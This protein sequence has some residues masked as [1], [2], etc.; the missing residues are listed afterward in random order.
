MLV[1]ELKN[2]IIETPELINDEPDYRMYSYKYTEKIVRVEN[3]LIYNDGRSLEFTLYSPTF[4]EANNLKFNI[5]V[6]NPNFN[7]WIQLDGTESVIIKSIV[8]SYRGQVIEEIQ[9]YDIINSFID[10]IDGKNKKKL[11]KDLEVGTHND[12]IPAATAVSH[13]LFNPTQLSTDLLE[14]YSTVYKGCLSLIKN[15][16]KRYSILIRSFVFNTDDKYL[17]LFLFSQGLKIKIELN[18]NAF[19]VPVFNGSLQDLINANLDADEYDIYRAA[20]KEISL[21]V[22]IIKKLEDKPYVTY[23]TEDSAF[24]I[25][26]VDDYIILTPFISDD[27]CLFHCL[28]HFLFKN[29][30]YYTMVKEK[31]IRYMNDNWKDLYIKFTDIFK[32]NKDDNT[33]MSEYTKNLSAAGTAGEPEIYCISKMYELP[34]GI[35]GREVNGIYSFSKGFGREYNKQPC[36]LY[37]NTQHYQL[38]VRRGDAIEIRGLTFSIN[39]LINIGKLRPL[40]TDVRDFLADVPSFVDFLDWNS[41][42]RRFYAYGSRYIIN[43]INSIVEGIIPNENNEAIKDAL[44]KGSLYNFASK[45]DLSRL[46]TIGYE[47]F[48]ENIVLSNKQYNVDNQLDYI[49]N[50]IFISDYFFNVQKIRYIMESNSQS[51]EQVIKDQNV[52]ND[53][54]FKK[55]NISSLVAEYGK[56]WIYADV[57]KYL[58]EI[59]LFGDDVTGEKIFKLSDKEIFE[60]LSS[61]R[62]TLNT[63][64]ILGDRK[65]IKGKNFLFK[66]E[67]NKLITGVGLSPNKVFKIL[68]DK[69]D[70]FKIDLFKRLNESYGSEKTV[71]ILKNRMPSLFDW[72]IHESLILK[73]LQSS[74][75]NDLLQLINGKFFYQFKS[76]SDIESYNP[77]D[78][79]QS[80]KKTLKSQ[81]KFEKLKKMID[82][83]KLFLN[84]GGLLS[85]V[86]PIVELS[87]HVASLIAICNENENIFVGDEEEEL[88]PFFDVELGVTARF[89]TLKGFSSF[90]IYGAYG[91]GEEGYFSNFLSSAGSYLKAGFGYLY[92]DSIYKSHFYDET[93]TL[94]DTFSKTK[95][96]NY[97]NI[98]GYFPGYLMDRADKYFR[99]ETAEQ[100][101]KKMMNANIEDLDIMDFAWRD[102]AIPK[103]IEELLMASEQGYSWIPSVMRQKTISEYPKDQFKVGGAKSDNL[104]QEGTRLYKMFNM[105]NRRTPNFRGTQENI[106]KFGNFDYLFNMFYKDDPKSSDTVEEMIKSD[107][108]FDKFIRKRGM[109][110]YASQ[111][112]GNQLKWLKRKRQGESNFIDDTSVA[113]NKKM[114]QLTNKTLQYANDM[115]NRIGQKRLTSESNLEVVMDLLSTGYIKNYAF[116]GA[117][118]ALATMGKYVLSP[119]ISMLPGGALIGQGVSKLMSIGCSWAG[120]VYSITLDKTRKVFTAPIHFIYEIFMGFGLSMLNKL[121]LKNTVKSLEDNKEVMKRLREKNATLDKDLKLSCIASLQSEK[122]DNEEQKKDSNKENLLKAKELLNNAITSAEDTQKLLSNKASMLNDQDTKKLTDLIGEWQAYEEAQNNEIKEL[123][124]KINKLRQS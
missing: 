1:D 13:F 91:S 42:L 96:T 44:L 106:D 79:S 67:I 29:S 6:L 50:Y 90:E 105:F 113:V 64:M 75:Y 11:E 103:H 88:Y 38:L 76:V 30:S 17:P 15:N 66:E 16:V 35:Y 12:I 72:V 63:N 114:Y 83:G 53:Q 41:I 77:F 98:F 55:T 120:S 22:N 110:E 82:L 52:T 61:K 84:F 9:D 100:N 45:L 93:D 46:A 34:I 70:Y 5:E 94:K 69:K 25:L 118:I 32:G 57:V 116:F 87:T 85:R 92:D 49:H 28:A 19:F 89:D 18:E 27:N 48:K 73:L 21:G 102:E 95:G 37:Y 65:V 62:E 81:E 117:L 112:F 86:N 7:N 97:Q 51:V 10:D 74:K 24:P 78:I 36:Y 124:D 4:I 3:P 68:K 101:E 33:L 20:L 71:N 31:V 99:A 59:N 122:G 40:F 2:G 39:D 56:E 119:L 111:Q 58:K 60:L 104:L 26:G 8:L 108:S 54:L 115:F 14:D 121:G 107:P 80:L 109:N 123:T 43:S 47:K 23:V